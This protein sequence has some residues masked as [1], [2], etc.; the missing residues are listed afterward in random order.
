MLYGQ[1][2]PRKF[3]VV[4]GCLVSLQLHTVAHSDDA[5]RLQ[6]IDVE[7][8]D[9]PA[10]ELPL[11]IGIS[12]ETLSRTPGSGGDPLRSLQSV[13]GMVFNDDESAEPAVRGARPGDNYYQ[14]DFAPSSYL[15]HQ[16]GAVSVYNGDLIES[17]SIYPSAYGP[18]FSGF[19]GGVF[20]V[21]L[22]DPAENRLQ[23]ALDIS[24][25]QGG[26][27]L[28]GPVAENQ[29]FYIAARRSYLDLI[30]DDLVEEEGVQVVDFPNYSDYQ[31]K[32]LWRIND[33]STLRFRANGAA[34][35]FDV[36]LSEDAEDVATDPVFVGRLYEATSF[37]EQAMVWDFMA[38]PKLSFKSLV[39]HNRLTSEFKAGGAGAIDIDADS[40]LMK[41]RMIYHVSE[42]HEIKVG[43]EV[44]A[45]ETSFD[46]ALNAPACTEFEPDC[47]YT[48]A[49]RLEVT[50]TKKINSFKAYLK[51][52]WYV[53]DRLTL[54]PGVAV[55]GENYLDK[56]FIEPRIA[57][58]YS[59]RD[60]LVLTAGYGVNHQIPA[61][62]QID[63]VFG[64]PDLKYIE[65]QH[66]SVGFQKQ[67]ADSWSL[68]SEIYFNSLS[69]LV[70][71]DDNTRYSNDGEGT[72]VG[73]DTLIRKQLTDKFSGWL[74]VSLSDAK[75]KD[76]RTGREFDFEYDQP[77]NASLVGSYKFSDKWS[78]GAKLWAHSGAPYTPVVGATPDPDNAGV[79]IPQYA[80]L[81]SE[82]LP[83]FKRLDLRVDRSFKP[84]GNRQTTAYFELLNITG[85]ENISG[86]SY[87]A[88]YSVRTPNEQLPAF[89]A[90]GLKTSF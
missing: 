75:R 53:N 69:N 7:A 88:D 82:R 62:D 68:S 64:N 19:S 16:D 78:L 38:N 74:S 79:F 80:E 11:G 32:Y 34:D 89:F 8:N 57:I 12:G 52:S 87:N 44:A 33:Q 77:V 2:R 1:Y 18:E 15:F 5:T 63:E 65:A 39:A 47:L 86:Y 46:V 54:F 20:D 50:E 22:R 72:A 6:Q 81:N 58:E 70:T 41:T 36:N 13:P 49:Q 71:S 17:F 29:S 23:G 43:A 61:I 48:G 9:E 26:F 66:V 83:A 24:F 55:H 3:S 4:I 73:L 21:K 85:S 10:T 84:K 59:L 76:K 56:Q 42:K 35:D 31:A 90:F 30:I 51:D 37:N 67:F 60:D 25:I 27:L 28:E 14:T 40:V 45:T